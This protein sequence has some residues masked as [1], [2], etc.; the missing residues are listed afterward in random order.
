MVTMRRN[1]ERS[2]RSKN[3]NNCNLL[4]RPRPINHDE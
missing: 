1:R 3:C 4:V 2:E